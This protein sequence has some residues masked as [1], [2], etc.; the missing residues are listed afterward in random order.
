MFAD[1][2]RAGEGESRRKKRLVLFAVLGLA[3]TIIALLSALYL[4]AFGY[5]IRR[6]VLHEGRLE[7]LLAKEPTVYQITE[8]LRE[9]APLVASPEDDVEL[10][11]LASRWLA[12]RD[13]ILVK[14]NHWPLAHDACPRRRSMIYFIYFD[15]E[16]IMR[17]FVYVSSS[18]YRAR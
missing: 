14:G 6:H 16:G 11:R 1:I 13:V 9:K 4:G 10:E 3:P 7:K 5:Q 18:E 17:D 15:T 12:R 8:G 2:E